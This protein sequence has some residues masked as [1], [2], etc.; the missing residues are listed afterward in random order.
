MIRKVVNSYDLHVHGQLMRV[1]HGDEVRYTTGDYDVQELLLNEP[2]GSKY[3][4]LVIYEFNGEKLHVTIKT[5]SG[6]HNSGVMLKGLVHTLIER[7]GLPEGDAYEVIY[8]GDSFILHRDQLDASALPDAVQLEGTYK[9]GGATVGVLE[10]DVYLAIE[11]ISEIK[12]R[13]TAQNEWDYTVYLNGSSLMVIDRYGG[14]I[15]HPVHEVLSVLHDLKRLESITHINGAEVDINASGK[16][17]D[18]PFY[19]ISNSQFYIDDTDIYSK[20]FIIK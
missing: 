18:H 16:K 4:N 17:Y 15:P 14:V 10:T 7:G 8:D 2:R 6:V 9:V 11:N 20:G 5:H 1:V 19:F 12:R 3:M 13:L